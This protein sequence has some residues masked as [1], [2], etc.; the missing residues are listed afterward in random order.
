MNFNFNTE[1]VS[2]YKSNSQRIR[3]MSEYWVS[4]N[5]FCP[6][7]GNAH[8]VTLNNNMPVADF[9]CDN[10]GEIYELKSKNKKNSTA[11]RPC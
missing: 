10:C 6:S 5:I 2:D 3:V 9:K 1:L 7:C 4:H 8:I 11:W